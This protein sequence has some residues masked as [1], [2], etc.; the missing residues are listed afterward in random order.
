MSACSPAVADSMRPDSN[1][2]PADAPVAGTS[3]ADVLR[4]LGDAE[5]TRSMLEDFRGYA[6]RRQGLSAAD[7]DDV[8]QDSVATYLVVRL[9]YPADANHFGLLFGIGRM[10]ARMLLRRV[11][12]RGRAK[13]RFA[14]LLRARRPEAA[15][16]EDAG[17]TVLDRVVR[18]ESSALI[19]GVLASIATERREMLLALAERR[20]SRLEMIAAAGAKPS[21]FD[22]RLRSA[23]LGLLRSLRAAGV[24]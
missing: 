15:R 24:A 22:T 21:T 7:A 19:R 9:R 17:G 18:A 14:D 16:G 2:P 12:S 11:A 10:K 13:R 23:R 6:R 5:R 3:H 20:S 4:A 1:R 8:F